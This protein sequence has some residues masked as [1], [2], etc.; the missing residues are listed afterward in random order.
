MAKGVFLRLSGLR[1]ADN[2]E[3]PAA[4]VRFPSVPAE[5]WVVDQAD[6]IDAG[7]SRAFRPSKYSA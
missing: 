7:M 5:K 1:S 2:S 3:D 4:K 6:A